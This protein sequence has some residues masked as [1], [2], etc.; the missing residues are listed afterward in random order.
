MF[1]TQLK[2]TSRGK[3][4]TCLKPEVFVERWKIKGCWFGIRWIPI[5]IKGK[6][7]RHFNHIQVVFIGFWWICLTNFRPMLFINISYLWDFFLQMLHVFWTMAVE[8]TRGGFLRVPL[9]STSRIIS[10][11]NMSPTW[12]S[13]D[14]KQPDL[15]MAPKQCP[16]QKPSCADICNVQG[17][18]MNNTNNYNTNNNCS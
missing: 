11:Y 9:V 2:N 7:M 15:D 16:P 17:I 14:N 4:K 3:N 6:I 8:N 1:S 5:G 12:N 10:S 18:L 13:R